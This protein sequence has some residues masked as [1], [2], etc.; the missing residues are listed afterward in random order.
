M[1]S[2][3]LTMM[4]ERSIAV[5]GVLAIDNT[6]TVTQNLCPRISPSVCRVLPHDMLPFKFL[7]L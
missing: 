7:A 2:I 4:K 3:V 5:G 6:D 1:R